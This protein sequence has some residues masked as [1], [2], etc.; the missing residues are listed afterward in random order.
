MKPIRKKNTIFLAVIV[1]VWVLFFFAYAHSYNLAEAHF[2]CA[3][4]H[5]ESAFLEGFLPS[6]KGKWEFIGGS[7]LPMIFVWEKRLSGHCFP[8]TFPNL[9]SLEKNSFLRC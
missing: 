8:R 1:S 5:L 4:P 9:F 6:L 3:S 7:A 2:L